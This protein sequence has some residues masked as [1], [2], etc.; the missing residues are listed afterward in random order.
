MV[1]IIVSNYIRYEI[2]RLRVYFVI[3]LACLGVGLET[4]I[5]IN[6]N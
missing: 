2:F 4:I 3:L 6:N 1:C 5:V